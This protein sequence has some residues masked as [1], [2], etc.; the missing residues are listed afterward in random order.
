MRPM[1]KSDVE[2]GGGLL[3][4]EDDGLLYEGTMDCS[5]A[6]RALSGGGPDIGVPMGLGRKAGLLLWIREGEERVLS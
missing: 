1:A 6:A 3:R 4:I 2:G 5:R